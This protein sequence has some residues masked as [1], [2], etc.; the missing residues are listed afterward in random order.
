[1][2]IFLKN[3]P[4]V[5]YWINILELCSSPFYLGVP[6]FGMQIKTELR[7]SFFTMETNRR[8]GPIF[9]FVW[10]P[11]L[12]LW[13]AEKG[14]GENDPKDESMMV[15]FSDKY[16]LSCF[17]SWNQLQFYCMNFN[18]SDLWDHNFLGSMKK[19]LP[20]SKAAK[21]PACWIVNIFPSLLYIIFLPALY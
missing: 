14:K 7:C 18:K 3:S 4:T 1:M 15:F 10:K 6:R 19:N 12:C 20:I 2:W 13:K 11:G 9:I 17:Y 8:V 16:K 21:K 5:C